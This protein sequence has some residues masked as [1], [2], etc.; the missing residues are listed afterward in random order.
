[1]PHSQPFSWTTV[2]GQVIT[3]Q[4]LPETY[5]KHIMRFLKRQYD[6]VYKKLV[7]AHASNGSS[8]LAD[9][10]QTTLIHIDMAQ[11]MISEE[12]RTREETI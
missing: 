10:T 12:L 4:T 9:T 2:D 7:A 1:M 5:L 6:V 3:L 11:Q 8:V